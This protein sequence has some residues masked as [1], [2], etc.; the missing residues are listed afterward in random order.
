MQ[1]GSWWHNFFVLLEEHGGLDVD[2]PNHLWLLHKLF[3][4]ALN[5]HIEQ[6]VHAW[7][8]HIIAIQGEHGCSPIDMFGFDMLVRGIRGNMV[9]G[10]DMVR[11]EEDGRDREML[12]ED[13]LGLEDLQFF[14]GNIPDAAL[15]VSLC[16]ITQIS[17]LNSH[18]ATG[19]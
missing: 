11:L 16:C 12:E 6:F 13:V 8:H 3:L 4:N 5:A 9:W 2:E 7:N 19:S 1:A 17:K 14:D 15:Q 10:E 18:D